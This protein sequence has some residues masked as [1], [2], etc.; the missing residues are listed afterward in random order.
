ME[1]CKT[2]V[3]A[4][5]S[6]EFCASLSAALKRAEGFQVVGT[7]N[8]GEQAI[9]TVSERKPD[10]LVLDLMLSKQDGLSVL[11]AISGMERRPIVF[12]TSGFITD[13]VASAAANLGVRYLMLK[14]CDL[15]A[16]VERMEEVRTVG[17]KQ[18]VPIRN[19]GGGIEAMVTNIIHEIGVPAHIKGYQYLR[20]DIIIAVEDM[21][22]INAITKVL[23]PQ[24]AKAFGTTPSRVERAIRHAIEVAWDRGDL[25]TLQRFFGYTVSNT[26]G[27]PTNSE[28]IALIADK[29][30]LQLKSSSAVNL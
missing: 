26:K 25:D 2:V 19:A 7:A 10:V 22:V 3:I 4:D 16:L 14:P 20:E 12:A 6:E 1:N 13:F 5:N 28:F 30:Q 17:T 24:V 27:K 9:R 18:P 23:Y 29:L 21:D 8:D 15:S 11:K